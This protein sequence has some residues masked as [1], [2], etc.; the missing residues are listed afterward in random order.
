MFR[1]IVTSNLEQRKNWLKEAD[2][3]VDKY[4]PKEQ[5]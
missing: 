3:I 1:I 2:G 5:K 4:F